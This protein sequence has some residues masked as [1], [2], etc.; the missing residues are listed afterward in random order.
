M[1]YLG[2]VEEHAG[3]EAQPLS[4]Y[5]ASCFDRAGASVKTVQTAMGHSSALT[6]DLYAHLFDADLDALAERLEAQGAQLV[7]G[8]GR[9]MSWRSVTAPRGVPE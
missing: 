5:A 4:H 8:R 1:A 2:R 6:L 3:R 7:D 9:A